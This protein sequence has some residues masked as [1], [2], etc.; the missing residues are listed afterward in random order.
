MVR[1]HRTHR[2][3]AGAVLLWSVAVYGLATVVFGLSRNFALTFACLALTG[4]ADTVSMVIRNVIRQLTTPDHLR[5]RMTSVEHGVLHGRPAARRTRGRAGREPWGAPFS[6]VTGGLGCLLA[7]ARGGGAHAGAAA[8]P[9]RLACADARRS[10][11]VTRR[12]GRGT[13]VAR[14]RGVSVSSH[15][16]TRRR[17]TATSNEPVSLHAPARP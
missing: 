3:G 5:G 8:L 9:A 4:A 14:G 2:S 11:R 10:R 13:W 12:A 16:F 6:V 15:R 1:V 7:V 17:L